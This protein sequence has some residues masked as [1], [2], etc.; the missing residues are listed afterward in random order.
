MRAAFSF[1]I[2][3]F[4][5]FKSKTSL[6]HGDTARTARTAK[7]KNAKLCAVRAVSPW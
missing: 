2:Y 7:C 5:K 1:E 4:K 3:F 6:N